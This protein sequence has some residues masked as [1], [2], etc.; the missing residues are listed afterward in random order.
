MFKTPES[1]WR[2]LQARNPLAASAFVY[3]VTS[4]RIFCRP[5]CPS[6]LARRANI[7]FFDSATDAQSA[8]F[9]ACKRC[10]PSSSFSSPSSSSQTHPLDPSKAGSIG[11]GPQ[12]QQKEATVR[13][14]CEL[15]KAAGGKIT[16]EQLAGGIGLSPRYFHGVFKAV[17]G[18]T[19]SGYAARVR[20]QRAAEESGKG[21]L[22][23]EWEGIEWSPPVSKYDGDGGTQS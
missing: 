16:L 7:V 1:R 2:A 18:V 5:A 12:Q 19:P 23:E 6:R 10:Q 21:T 11:V 9:R 14:A 4:T 15:V 17:M 20:S 22:S 8:G 13:K 3:A